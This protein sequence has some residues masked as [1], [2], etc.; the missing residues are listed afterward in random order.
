MLRAKNLLGNL[1]FSF[2][3]SFSSGDIYTFAWTSV[4]ECMTYICLHV[5]STFVA[6]LHGALLHLGIESER[7][8]GFAG[9]T[10]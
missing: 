5:Q 2:Y 1:F 9:E 7:K 6:V 8:Q 4:L 3:S 10:F